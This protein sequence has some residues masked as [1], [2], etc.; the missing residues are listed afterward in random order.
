MKRTVSFLTAFAFMFTTAFA[1]ILGSE[2]VFHNR[3]EVADDI[4][5]TTLYVKITSSD[6]SSEEAERTI[7][8]YNDGGRYYVTRFVGQVQIGG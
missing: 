8:V 6:D 7:Y 5:Y 2:T 4:Y 1:S 3:I